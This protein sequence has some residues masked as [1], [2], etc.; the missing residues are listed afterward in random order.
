M[1][2]QPIN[3]SQGHIKTMQI[4]TKALIMGLIIFALMVIFLYQTSFKDSPPPI[5]SMYD[6]FLGISA[7]VLVLAGLIALQLYRKGVERAKNLTGSLNDKLNIYRSTL[8]TYL[9]LSEAGGMLSVI[10]LFLTGDMRLLIVTGFSVLLML[11]GYVTKKKLVNEL[12]LNWQEE[13]D[14]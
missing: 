11:K 6:V 8:I 14:L 5:T 2:Q 7:A 1:S 12:Q 3:N 10:F 9:A 13:Q 4:L